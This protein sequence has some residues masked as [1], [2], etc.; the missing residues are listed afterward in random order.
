MHWFTV[1]LLLSAVPARPQPTKVDFNRDV[2]PIFSARCQGCHGA[3]QQMAG[4][5]LDSGAAVLKGATDGMVI[6]PGK[7]AESR[8]IERV[9]STKKGFGMPPV[10]EPLSADQISTPRAWM[11]MTCRRPCCIAWVWST[12]A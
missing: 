12:R 4:L 8:L 7:S 1:L 10:G 9:T 2:Q 3:Q 11:C 6:Q 5:R